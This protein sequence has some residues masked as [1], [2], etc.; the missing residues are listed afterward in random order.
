MCDVGFVKVQNSLW[1]LFFFKR[2]RGPANG[3]YLVAVLLLDP[4]VEAAQVHRITCFTTAAA[5]ALHPRIV[6][7]EWLK[8]DDAL[9]LE[10]R[11][12][13]NG[14]RAIR[15]P[16]RRRWG[17]PVECHTW[18]ISRELKGAAKGLGIDH[19][20]GETIVAGCTAILFLGQVVRNGQRRR[21]Y[22]VDRSAAVEAAVGHQKLLRRR[23]GPG[24]K[25]ATWTL[26]RVFGAD[27]IRAAAAAAAAAAEE[28]AVRGWSRNPRRAGDGRVGGKGPLGAGVPAAIAEERLPRVARRRVVPGDI[29]IASAIVLGA[30]HRTHGFRSSTLYLNARAS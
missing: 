12:M 26:S 25:G 22:K 9:G 27:A 13:R 23:G 30:A 10:V 7:G 5:L 29:G 4:C 6:G 19:A 17:M 16:S 21:R 15:N 24:S 28:Q 8:T 2:E 18:Y 14:T 3:A 1:A 11:H 20:E